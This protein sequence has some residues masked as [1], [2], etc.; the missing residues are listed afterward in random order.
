MEGSEPLLE[1]R[2]INS[3][4]R[5]RTPVHSARSN[6]MQLTPRILRFI[7]LLPPPLHFAAFTEHS[8]QVAMNICIQLWPSKATGQFVRH[9][10]SPFPPFLYFLSSFL[11]FFLFSL[12]LRLLF[13]PVFRA[14]TAAVVVDKRKTAETEGDNPLSLAQRCFDE[15]LNDIENSWLH[16][17]FSISFFFSRELDINQGREC[18]LNGAK[19]KEFR[20]LSPPSPPSEY[21]NGDKRVNRSFPKFRREYYRGRGGLIN[22]DKLLFIRSNTS[23]RNN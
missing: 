18:P 15:R 23:S 12:A 11:S 5:K 16:F 2:R 6:E 17:P 4:G 9:I 3:K 22:R 14:T 20:L 21:N 19:I 13:L 7:R 8:G 10:S 1:G